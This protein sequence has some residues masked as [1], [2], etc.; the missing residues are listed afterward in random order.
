[1]PSYFY[2]AILIALCVYPIIRGIY[3]FRKGK[4]T[5]YY[6]KGTNKDMILG[7]G[8]TILFF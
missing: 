4:Y 7:F 8:L 6:Q 2:I 5:P 1:M 3:L